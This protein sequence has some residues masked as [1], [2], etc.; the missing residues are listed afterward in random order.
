MERNLPSELAAVLYS[1]DA[2][3]DRRGKKLAPTPPVLGAVGAL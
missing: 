1:T 3:G 2:D